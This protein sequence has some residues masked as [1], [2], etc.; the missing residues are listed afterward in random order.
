MGRII[1]APHLSPGSGNYFCGGTGPANARHICFYVMEE[2][3]RNYRTTAFEV[4]VAKES[5]R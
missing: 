2:D 3:D 5:L 4:G 1:R